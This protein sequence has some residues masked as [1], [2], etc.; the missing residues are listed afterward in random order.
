[1]VNTII[2]IIILHIQQLYAILTKSKDKTSLLQDALTSVLFAIHDLFVKFKGPF[3]QTAN[4]VPTDVLQ[5][6][7][8]LVLWIQQ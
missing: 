8:L 6:M 3:S 7:S 4:I 2:F 1:M 5:L